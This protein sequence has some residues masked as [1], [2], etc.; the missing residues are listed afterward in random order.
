MDLAL[1]SGRTLG[2][3]GESG[4]GKSMLALSIMGLVPRPGRVAAGRVMFEGQD[5]RTLPPRDMRRVRGRRIAMIFP[6]PMASLNPVYTAG[7]QLVEAIRAHEPRTSNQALRARGVAALDRVRIADAARRFDDYPHQMSGEMRQRVMIAMALVCQPAV[8]I[9]DEPTTALD[10]TAQAQIL[11]LLRALQAETGIAIIMVTHDVGVMGEMAD[12]VAVMYAG[13]VVERSPAAALFEDPQHPYTL[14][15]LGSKPRMDATT[16][17]LPAIPGVAPPPFALPAGCRFHPRCVF[18]EPVCTREAPEL[19][20]V[21][22]A[23]IA[24]CHMAPILP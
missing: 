2:I 20:P 4:C 11:A 24:A 7:E 16:F 15:L 1:E 10:V 5:L 17:R 18:V 22:P 14:G 23:H 19:R 8:L 3:V 12:E 21:A 9:A 13:R 6:D